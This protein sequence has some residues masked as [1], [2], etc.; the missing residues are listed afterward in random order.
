MEVNEKKR[1]VRILFFQGV[2]FFKK[3]YGNSSELFIVFR[4]T[5]L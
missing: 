5:T 4:E 1:C 2:G 3:S